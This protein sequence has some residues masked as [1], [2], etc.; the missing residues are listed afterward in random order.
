[1]RTWMTEMREREGLSLDEMARRC[2]VGHILLHHLEAGSQTLPTLALRI[3]AGYGMTPEQC[4]EIGKD[5]ALYSEDGRDR[6]EF[7]DTWEKAERRQEP[8]RQPTEA[9][10]PRESAARQLRKAR[11][12]A[13]ERARL[14]QERYS[15]RVG[16]RLRYKISRFDISAGAPYL[17]RAKLQYRLGQ[18]GLN[19][20]QLANAAGY[21]SSQ[22]RA[23]M[24][25]ST[26]GS[27]EWEIVDRLCKGLCCEP[28]DILRMEAVTQ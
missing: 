3:G 12:A 4:R 26:H 8:L 7:Q 24:K 16:R 2:G 9:A 1:M 22:V 17:D 19:V 18:A 14:E 6:P 27:I 11:A 21:E 23:L 5:F 20:E 15:S 13:R 25:R 10:K 28:W